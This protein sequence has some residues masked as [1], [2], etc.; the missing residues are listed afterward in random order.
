MRIIRRT[1]SAKVSSMSEE[2]RS[3]MTNDRITDSKSTAAHKSITVL[4]HPNNTT[5]DN[6]LSYKHAHNT[7]TQPSKS[8]T[9]S[10]P[11]RS[12][13]QPSGL[14]TY[15]VTCNDPGGVDSDTDS[16]TSHEECKN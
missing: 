5:N 13:S 8:A 1:N 4:N 3:S 14:E 10:L 15:G 6:I 9:I 12:R 7:N 2:S 11:I 16:A